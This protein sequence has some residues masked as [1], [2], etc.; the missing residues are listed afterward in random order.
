MVFNLIYHFASKENLTPHQQNRLLNVPIKYLHGV[1]IPT[2]VYLGEE[3]LFKKNDFLYV[4][5]CG[6]DFYIPDVV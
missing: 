5:F 1:K 2:N 6:Y 4:R 3:N